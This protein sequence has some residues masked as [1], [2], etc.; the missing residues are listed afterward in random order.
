MVN[1]SIG[2]QELQQAAADV[3]NR[4][5][6]LQQ[7]LRQA[8]SAVEQVTGAAYRTRTASRE[9]RNAHTEWNQATG[10]LV[11]RLEEVARAIEETR[12]RDEQTD[13]DAA[14]RVGNIR[15]NG[16]GGGGGGGAAVG[17]AAGGGAAAVG[18]AAV[19]RARHQG[20]GPPGSTPGGSGGP[21]NRGPA[22]PGGPGGGGP[23]GPGGPPGTPRSPAGAGGPGDGDRVN[24]RGQPFPDNRTGE[25]YGHQTWGQAQRRLTPE[26]R[27]ALLDYAG[28]NHQR[29]NA[30]HRGEVPMND[31]MARQTRHLDEALGLQRTPEPIHVVRV[32]SPREFGFPRDGLEQVRQLRPGDTFRMPGYTSTTL[33]PNANYSSPEFKPVCLDIMVS[34]G[35][36]AMFLDGV[37]GMPEGELL[38]G[39]GLTYEVLGP[40]VTRSDGYVHV[41]VRIRPR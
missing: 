2:H 10:D 26:Q 27:D 40:P 7:F 24:P 18:G 29:L 25:R 28:S 21:G 19:A 20:G 1:I 8:A 34:R 13:R 37:R 15:G 6:E 17:A 5:G 36:P 14:G 39:R 22:G 31:H 16:G 11:N 38:L 33:G 4:K 35:V 32:T 9:F 12:Q 3:R 23:G 41:P 30:A